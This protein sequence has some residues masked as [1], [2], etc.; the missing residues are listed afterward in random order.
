MR[1][2]KL[3]LPAMVLA[4]CQ[5]GWAQSPNYGLGKAP[6]AEEIRA[7]DIAISPDGKE[8]P[9]GRGSAKEGATLYA[10]KCAACHGAT[11]SGGRAPQLIKTDNTAGPPATGKEPPCLAPCIRGANVMGIHSP[12]ATTIWDYINRGMPF[13]KEGSLKPDEVY[14]LTAF[15]LYKNGVIPEDQVLDATSLPQVKM[16]NRDGYVLPEWKHGMPRPFP[17]KP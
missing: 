17:N 14:A 1:L 7:L 12:Y 5:P 16:P 2:P 13:G 9:P 15:L 4:V 11:G 8:L 3:L 6:T 10:Q